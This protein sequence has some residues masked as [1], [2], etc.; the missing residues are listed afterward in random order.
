MLS[1]KPRLAVASLGNE[2]SI[3]VWDTDSG[4][5][6]AALPFRDAVNGWAL[7]DS[8]AHILAAT[9]RDTVLW[10]LTAERWI[11]QAR[12][13]ARRPLSSDEARTYGVAVQ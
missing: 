3:V 1:S 2:Q 10:S 5:L 12:R 13:V 11:E 4:S 6:I 7:S 8:G 9:E